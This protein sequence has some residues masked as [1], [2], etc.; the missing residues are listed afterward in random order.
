MHYKNYTSF[1]IQYKSL[2]N[3]GL[4]KIERTLHLDYNL[5][6]CNQAC[7]MTVDYMI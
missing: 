4:R 7:I 6:T 5:I 1:K 2:V 3:T